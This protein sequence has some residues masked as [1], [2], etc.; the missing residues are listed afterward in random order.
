MS[1]SELRARIES[2]ESKMVNIQE[3]VDYLVEKSESIEKTTN[4]TNI[5]CGAQR[6]VPYVSKMVQQVEHVN[7]LLE[8][9]ETESNTLKTFSDQ[10]YNLILHLHNAH[11]HPTS[12]DVDNVDTE[13]SGSHTLRP[14]CADITNKLMEELNF[15]QDTDQNGLIFGTDFIF[16]TTDSKIPDFIITMCNNV[17]KTNNMIVLTWAEYEETL[18]KG[19][20]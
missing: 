11:F 12:H 9:L 17:E 13:L 19:S 3:K 1:E 10:L 7:V 4:I 18:P 20:V 2:L 14:F 6:V 8:G 5:E 16:D 15:L